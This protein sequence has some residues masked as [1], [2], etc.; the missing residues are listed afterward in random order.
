[1]EG[2]NRFEVGERVICIEDFSDAHCLDM[3][4]R[5]IAKQ[6]AHYPKVG[7]ELIVT[8]VLDGFVRFHKY[9]PDDSLRW[10]D[11][12]GF[13]PAAPYSQAIKELMSASR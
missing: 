4:N 5:P 11:E 3:E 8:G 1:M 13:E 10:W 12:E 6:D 9:D 2:V 7:E